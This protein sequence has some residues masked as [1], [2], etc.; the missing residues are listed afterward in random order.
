VPPGTLDP[1]RPANYEEFSLANGFV[2]DPWSGRAR[3]GGLVNVSY[4]GGGCTGWASSAPDFQVNYTAG[5]SSLRFYFISDGGADTTLIV[6]DPLGNWQCNDDSYGT[7]HPTVD[8]LGTAP[9]GIYDVWIGSYAEGTNID[10]L[11]YITELDANH[12]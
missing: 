10:G 7:L 12:P 1:T 5:D 6:N 2:P 3:S 11:L 8:F 4:L 9:S